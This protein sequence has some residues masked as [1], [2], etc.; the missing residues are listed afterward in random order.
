MQQLRIVTQRQHELCGVGENA[1]VV[2]HQRGR[3]RIAQ[4]TAEMLRASLR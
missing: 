1:I 4:M 3:V 2:H